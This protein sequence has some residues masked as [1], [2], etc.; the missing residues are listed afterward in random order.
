MHNVCSNTC[1]VNQQAVTPGR[2]PAADRVFKKMKAR[3]SVRLLPPPSPIYRDKRFS[4]NK[5]TF[6]LR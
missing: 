5:R 2:G 6:L 3:T 1:I 4:F